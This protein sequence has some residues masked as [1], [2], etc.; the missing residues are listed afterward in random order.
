M[1][2]FTYDIGGPTGS[3]VQPKGGVIDNSTAQTISNVGSALGSLFGGLTQAAGN[4]AKAEAGAQKASIMSGYAQQVSNFNTAVEQGKMSWAEAKSRQRALYNKTIASYP[5]ITEDITKFQGDLNST[6]GIGDVL[7]KGTA[8]DQQIQEDTKKATASGFISPSMTI[9]SQQAGLE[10]YR[11]MQHNLT[12]MDYQKSQLQLQSAKLEIVSKSE[13][14]AASRANRQNAQLE[15]QMKRNKV[16]LQSSLADVA[17]TYYGKTRQDMAN[18]QEAIDT[19]KMTP[20]EGLRATNEVR[21]NFNAQLQPIRGAADPTYVDNLTKPIIDMMSAQEQ[22]LSG[23]ITKEV[24][25][26]RIDVNTSIASLTIMKDPRLAQAAAVSKIFPNLSAAILSDVGD[27]VTKIL[28]DNSKSAG[29]PANVMSESQ[30]VKVETKTYLK[31]IGDISTRILEKD[32]TIVNPKETMTELTLNVNNVLKGINAFSSSIDNPAQMNNVTSFLASKDFINFQKAGGQV[33]QSSAA[34]VKGIVSASYNNAVI[35][36]IQKEWE[37]NKTVIGY[38]TQVNSKLAA[39]TAG[40]VNMPVANTK[41]TITAVDYVWTGSSLTFR[42]AK[43]MEQNRGAVEKAKVLNSK[44][45]PLVNKLVRMNAHLDGSEDYT[46]YFNEQEQ[47]FFGQVGGETPPKP[48]ARIPMTGLVEQGNIDLTNRPQ[49]KNEDGTISTVRSMS[50]NDEDS[51]K[52]ILI[53]T[54]SESGEILSDDAAIDIYYKT[55][56]HLGK[57]DT[58]EQATKY[59]EKL[60]NEQANFYK[61]K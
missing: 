34:S 52:E 10:R 15:L 27:E 44:V 23:K 28:R 33:N 59:A 8:V 29:V 38:P 2:E 17:N 16:N 3:P 32:P 20:E 26:N 57:F 42:P 49:V 12:M 60:H 48:D 45:A 55:G 25:Q 54:V 6:A 22:F 58:P 5:G 43:G 18:I 19:G 24:L 46:K 35:P 40:R 9:E 11:D 50:F 39:A 4:T 14:I 36:A 51:G 41:E 31:G 1:A 53:P 61:V 56:R 21:N 13:S 7:A 30:D 47:A 37:M